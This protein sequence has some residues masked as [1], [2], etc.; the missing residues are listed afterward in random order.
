[1][2]NAARPGVLYT[3]YS[4][5]VTQTPFLSVWSYRSQEYEVGRPA[6]V[7]TAAGDHEFWL[8]RTDPLL[9]TI[10]PGTPLSVVV[11]LGDAWAG[12]RTL[13]S[14]EVI[15]ALCVMGP[16]T[17]PR[18][19]CV[20][21][22]VHAVGAVLPAAFAM[23]VLSCPPADL[24]DRTVALDA[25]WPRHRIHELLDAVC[26]GDDASRAARLRD[27]LLASTTM[28][29][30]ADVTATAARLMTLRGGDVSV[31]AM[32]A[33]CALSRQ[34]FTRRFRATTGLPPKQFAR[35]SRFQRLVHTL[36]TTNVERWAVEAP[37][38]GFYDQ[39]HMV[40][41]FREFAG[42]PPTQFF[43]PRGLELGAPE[44]GRLRGRPHT[45]L[46]STE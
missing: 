43:R 33:R 20:G 9:N 13:V 35:I 36:L 4:R 17:R 19:M 16:V 42:A 14:A 2:S 12:G 15:P 18:V 41:E 27:V 22:S 37:G 38:S 24:V 25:L 11:N 32:A 8:D 10:L 5:L 39:S 28:T 6:V 29:R 30:A 45:W 7:R 1:M 44:E 21:P 46:G 3:E 40:N 26:R 34:Q 23:N 31:E